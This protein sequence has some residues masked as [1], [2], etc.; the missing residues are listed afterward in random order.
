MKPLTRRS[1]IRWIITSGA[2]LA[3]PFP[4]PAAEKGAPAAAPKK[5]LLSSESNEVCHQVRD[6]IALPMPPPSRTVDVVVVGAGPSGVAAAD[7]LAGSDF[8]V[9]EKEPRVGGNA[10]AE[11]W[12]GLKYATGS[13]WM[14]FFDDR[15]VQLFKK[16]KVELLPIKSYDAG[17]FE[18][19]WIPEFWDADPE[20]PRIGELPYNDSVKKGFRDF[21]R[22]LKKIDV[23]KHKAKLDATPFYDFLKGKPEPLVSYWDQ[24]GL[25]NWGADSPRSSALVGIQAARDWAKDP[26]FTLE[27]GL[28]T[29]P[30]KVFDQ[31]PEEMRGRFLLSAPVYKVKK[32]GKRALVYFFHDGK[33]NCVEAKAV[34]FCAP[35]MIAARVV[36]DLPPKQREA[37]AAMRYAP[38]PVYNLC[39]TRRVADI[40]YDS[41]LVGGKN[42]A[43]FIQADWVT[44]RH[45]AKPEE[46]QVLSVY[47][48]MLEKERGDLLDDE[49]TLAR[50]ERATREVLA[51]LPGSEAHLAE[52]RVFR[53]GHPM[54][55]STPG[56]HT[57]V[58][59]AARPDR[60]PVYFAHSDQVGELSDLAYG[61]LSGIEAAQ[62]AVKHL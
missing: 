35:K 8:L 1:F 36:E 52:V 25:S 37:M 20:S 61:M 30:Q 9:L 62:K 24:F 19:K 18:G 60:P 2:A 57:K 54:P 32:S 45:D 56:W 46:P 42:C 39:F 53:R 59:A 7:A 17:C 22:E 3:C 16:W 6:G 4:L 48:P 40:G 11:S 44:R 55:M 5:P 43:D 47:A 50:A 15:I 27:G 26:R 51:T 49:E 21:L 23:V 10:Y 58:Q 33:P 41:Y 12:N 13:A 34:V 29:I 38:F 14:T 31:F 28:G